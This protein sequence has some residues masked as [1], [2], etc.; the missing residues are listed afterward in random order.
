MLGYLNP[1]FPSALHALLLPFVAAA[2]LDDRLPRLVRLSA[3]VVGAGLW[4]TN[5]GLAT[6]GIWL[7][8]ALV[9]A[10]AVVVP[11][12]NL[13]KLALAQAILAGAGT[14][15][16]WAAVRFPTEAGVASQLQTR[17]VDLTS[18]SFRDQLWLRSLQ[19]TR[20]DPL[21]GAGPMRFAT[22]PHQVAAHP[23]NWFLQIAAEWGLPAMIMTV[24]L[25]V[26]FCLRALS[27]GTMNRS[28]VQGAPAFA[29]L[30]FL[31]YGLI[32]GI[33][34]MPVSQTLGFLITGVAL[35][36]A[37][38][39]AHGAGCATNRSTVAL[40]VVLSSAFFVSYY[41]LSTYER[42]RELQVRLFETVR[43]KELSPR[44]WEQGLLLAPTRRE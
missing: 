18:L 11:R 28:I 21:L 12:W 6:R 30:V 31:S 14:L 8:F 5:L 33:H 36:V 7:V 10:A 32:D 3:F 2:A 26:L 41:A 35:G 39:P 37:S 25:V 15:A 22:D 13:R 19:L 42:Q 23:H 40:A 34:V 9:C 17:T 4:A 27:A 38:V 1:R 20:E 24:V 43:H 29:L 44:F 16:Y